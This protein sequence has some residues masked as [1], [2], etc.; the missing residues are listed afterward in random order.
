[1]KIYYFSDEKYLD[2]KDFFV[3]SMKDPWE[4]KF[5][6]LGI[7]NVDK[8]KPGSGENIWKFKTKMVL[9]AIKKNNNDII[10]VS[11]IDIV[12]FK[13][14]IPLINELMKDKEILFQGEYKD[15]GI[16]IGFVAIKCND[17]TYNFWN[18]VLKRINSDKIWDQKIVNELIY[19]ENYPIKWGLFPPTIAARSHKG[20]LKGIHLFHAN[21][22]GDKEKKFF[23]LNRAIKANKKF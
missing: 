10:V 12:F 20:E 2:M 9:S 18:T 1:M 17:N 21:V 16:N 22:A 7:I 8:T 6:D 13:P 5:T 19:K 14:V 23:L 3:K 4:H 15:S 11:D